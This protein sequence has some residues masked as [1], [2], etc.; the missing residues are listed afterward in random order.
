MQRTERVFVENLAIHGF[1]GL[2]PA[3]KTLGQKFFADIECKVSR[4]SPPSDTMEDAVD[5]G[6]LCDI[7]QSVSASGPF[8]LIET[9]AERIGQAVLEGFPLVSNVRVRVRKPNAPIRHFI[10]HVG[11][12]IELARDA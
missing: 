1:H 12:E 2:I 6:A 5:Y 9:L 8:N 11:V 10:D 7:A 3:E 4:S